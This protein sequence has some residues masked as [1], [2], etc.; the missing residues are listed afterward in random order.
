[1]PPSHQLR[2]VRQIVKQ[3]EISTNEKLKLEWVK[4]YARLISTLKRSKTPMKTK[5]KPGKK[6]DVSV[7]GP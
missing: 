1:M 6:P 5:P 4:V 3:A 7:L 2:I